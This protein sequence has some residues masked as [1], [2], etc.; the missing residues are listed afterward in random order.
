MPLEDWRLRHRGITTLLWLHVPAIM[1][2]ALYMGVGIGHALLETAAIAALAVLASSSMLGRRL[3]SVAA[4]VGLLMSSAVLVHLSGGV[5]ELHFHYFV[6]VMV[7]ALYQDWVPF[8]LAIT[9]VL[10]QH[11]VVGAIDPR[12]VY[13]HP[14]A[15]ANPWKW[16]GI[17]ALFLGGAAIAVIVNWRLHE[18]AREQGERTARQGAERA[19]ELLLLQTASTAIARTTDA[20]TI[21]D[22][23]VE[24]AA[25][26]KFAE[27]SSFYRWYPEDGALRCIAS[28]GHDLDHRPVLRPGEGFAGRIF[29]DLHWRVETDL[30]PL[31]RDG[32]AMAKIGVPIVQGGTPLGVLVVSCRR[33]WAVLTDDHARLLALFGDQAGAALSKALAFEHQRLAV[34]ELERVN[35]AKS[36]FVSVVSHEFRTPLTGIQGFS[37]MIRDEDFTMEE[38]KEF[39]ADINMDARRLSRMITDV[40]DLDRMESGRVTLHAEDGVDLHEIIRDVVAMTQPVAPHHQ[41]AVELDPLV[42]TLTADG[43]AAT[44]ILTNLLSNAIK[45]SPEGGAILIRTRVADDSVEVSVRDHGMGIPPEMLNAVFERYTRVESESARHIQGTGLGLPIVRQ[46]VEMHRGHVWVESELGEGSTFYFT[47]PLTSATA[48]QVAIGGPQ[49]GKARLL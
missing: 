25:G 47:L 3:R 37:E 38:V 14:D 33:G 43:D 36:E 32:P 48:E 11:G 42:P 22:K 20:D 41:I 21:I 13:N 5:V 6:M 23:V 9:F 35:R 40:L 49:N 27:T 26:L 29:A 16:A 30:A 45:Y 1:L 44:Q 39:A 2:F 46:I 7:V 24:A 8:L 18:I 12:G 19:E 15:I 17:H 34:E 10:V 4:S 31:Q 28:R